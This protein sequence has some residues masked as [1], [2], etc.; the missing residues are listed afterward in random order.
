MRERMVRR[1][2]PKTGVTGGSGTTSRGKS[3]GKKKGKQ[4]T[5]QEESL[6][7]VRP[8]S[9]IIV[10]PGTPYSRWL[11]YDIRSIAVESR[12]REIATTPE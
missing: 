5:R 3:R 8:S 7:G 12:N 10:E 2:R 11:G 1:V 6:E 4:Q 9:G